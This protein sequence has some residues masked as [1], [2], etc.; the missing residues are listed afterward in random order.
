MNTLALP[1]R[2]IDPGSEG[3]AGTPPE[4][5]LEPVTIALGRFA[6]I[7]G[8]GLVQALSEDYA[9]V[10]IIATDLD[11]AELVEIAARDS[12]QVLA[13]DESTAADTAVLDRLKAA[14][15][16]TAVVVLAQE[17]T[18]AFGMLLL[19]A[20]ATCIG[21]GGT[22]VDI[23][24]ALHFAAQGGRVFLSSD[25][26]RVERCY[27]DRASLLTPRELSVLGYLSQGKSYDEISLALQIRPETV[28]RHTVNIRRKLHMVSRRELIGLPI[29]R[30]SDYAEAG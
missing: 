21:L 5:R 24:G 28:R 14:Q 2:P 26:E 22:V 17:P 16:A 18:R 11:R 8:R 20:G 3:E 29:P 30:A 15:P 12:P 25:G 10:Q 27:P 1:A 7:I 13:L 23:I 6:E 9:S 4:D 19:A